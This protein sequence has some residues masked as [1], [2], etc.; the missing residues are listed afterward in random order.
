M[1]WFM[2]ADAVGSRM[3]SITSERAADVVVDG[4]TARDPFREAVP[5]SIAS[6]RFWHFLAMRYDVRPPRP[7]FP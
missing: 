5:A 7:E 2:A 4:G 1:L 3:D 6:V